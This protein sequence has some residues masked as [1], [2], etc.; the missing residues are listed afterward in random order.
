MANVRRRSSIGPRSPSERSKP[1]RRLS[2]FGTGQ[3]TWRETLPVSFQSPYQ[4]AL[5][6]GEP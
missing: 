2:T 5:T 4:A 1:T 3:K 6:L